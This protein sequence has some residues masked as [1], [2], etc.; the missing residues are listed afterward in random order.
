[1]ILFYLIAVF[2]LEEGFMQRLSE[3]VLRC[4]FD[5]YEEEVNSVLLHW[6]PKRVDVISGEYGFWED[7]Y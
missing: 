1:M 6:A 7:E 3:A 2:I 4:E 5:I